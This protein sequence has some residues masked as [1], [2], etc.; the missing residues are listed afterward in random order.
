MSL[1]NGEELY[2]GERDELC[3]KDGKGTQIYKDGSLYE[4]YWKDGK[5]NGKGRLIND[6]CDVYIGEWKDDR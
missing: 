4:G 5:R 1:K 3:R 6:N 2:E